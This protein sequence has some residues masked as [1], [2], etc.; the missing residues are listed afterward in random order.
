MPDDHAAGPN[1][2]DALTE[3]KR[4]MATAEA[5]EG[6]VALREESARFLD[7]RGESGGA[8]GERREA[9][10]ERDAARNAWDRARALQGATQV[11]ETGLE[12]PIPSRESFLANIDKVAPKSAAEA[13]NG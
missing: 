10:L 9:D 1:Q 11:T 12:I 6:R 7:E 5:H 8:E 4:L 2:R 3:A 13:A